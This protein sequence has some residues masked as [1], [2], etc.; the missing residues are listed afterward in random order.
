MSRKN[1]NRCYICGRFVGEQFA[2][3]E[4]DKL[5]KRGRLL[6]EICLRNIEAGYDNRR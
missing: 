3:Y 5:S 2:G 4:T 1:L 6:C